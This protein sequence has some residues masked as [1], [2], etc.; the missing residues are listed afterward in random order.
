MNG[1]AWMGLNFYDFLK[2]QEV[3]RIINNPVML[4]TESH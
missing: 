4:V 1:V 3:Y 2:N